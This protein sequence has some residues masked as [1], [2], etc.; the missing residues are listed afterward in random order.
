MG[1]TDYVIIAATMKVMLNALLIAIG[2]RW[3]IKQQL[4]QVITTTTENLTK[5]SR[6]FIHYMK[7][8]SF[9]S[10]W[11]LKMHIRYIE[12]T[13]IKIYVSMASVKLLFILTSCIFIVST[14]IVYLK[15]TAI[16]MSCAI[17]AISMFIPFILLDSLRHYNMQRIRGDIVHFL[18]L[19]GQWYIVSEDIM[20]CFEKVS[21]QNLS[22]PMGTYL[23]DFV[24]QVKRGLDVSEALYILNRKVDSEFFGT[25]I[26]NIDQ[27]LNNRGDVGIML[28]NLEDEAY[29][30]QEELNRRNISSLHDKIIIY[31][32]MFLVIVI[33]YRL[34]MLNAIT[35]QFYFETRLGR[36]LIVVYCILYL[37]GFFIA[38]GLS[39]L[40]Y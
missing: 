16:L 34:L 12:Q 31:V 19:L 27:A 9:L 1:E 8:E 29:Q 4:K 38:T 18:S 36:A 15:S 30:L 11:L 33:A 39:K 14:A 37:I 6:D 28:R 5:S 21:E 24:T 7:G 23:T 2:M 20:K 17:G 10:P 3:L 35:E 32:V 25:F 22:E 13:N 40:E 26:V